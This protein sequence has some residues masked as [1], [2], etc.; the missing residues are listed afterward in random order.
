MD[1]NEDT[2]LPHGLAARFPGLK[3]LDLR[4][5]YFHAATGE[6]LAGVILGLPNLREL[7]GYLDI[8]H[9]RQLN[10]PQHLQQVPSPPGVGV[11]GC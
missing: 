9:L 6:E 7:L 11:G 5:I 1:I 10:S 4:E 3:R 2:A 8:N